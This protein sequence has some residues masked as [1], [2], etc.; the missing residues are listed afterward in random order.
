[1]VRVLLK[2]PEKIASKPITAEVIMT[3]KVSLNI[4]AA[5]VNQQGGEMLVEIPSDQAEKVMEE[6][7]KRGVIIEPHRPVKVDGEECIE[8]G[9]C[10]S[11]CPVDAITFQ[12]DYSISFNQE[13]CLGS[14]CRLCV[15]ACPA[16]AI[17][18]V[19]YGKENIEGGKP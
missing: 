3:Q 5:H 16:R 10:Y 8:C 11:L 19:E 2:F 17:K 9:A 1:M 15:D 13:K 4:L 18:V 6:F 7:Q 14:T 12:E